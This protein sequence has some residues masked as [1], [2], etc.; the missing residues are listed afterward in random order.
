MSSGSI[1][2][3]GFAAEH[4]TKSKWGNAK[5]LMRDIYSCDTSCL[6]F[7]RERIEQ[8]KTKY[9]MICVN[10]EKQREKSATQWSLESLFFL[11]ICSQLG[12]PKCQRGCLAGVFETSAP[13]WPIY[14]SVVTYST[15]VNHCSFFKI[16]T[17]MLSTC[18][19]DI[20]FVFFFWAEPVAPI[21]FIIVWQQ[22]QVSK[23]YGD[24]QQ[25]WPKLFL[26][27]TIVQIWVGSRVHWRK[28]GDCS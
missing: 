9:L 12:Q 27:R 7:R 25:S 21:S 4:S 5:T 3:T 16:S 18:A 2:R 26:T 15:H 14:P 19:K 23:N 13:W 8:A 6:M 22:L 11:I 1:T 24:S 20:R 28:Q 17:A 10:M